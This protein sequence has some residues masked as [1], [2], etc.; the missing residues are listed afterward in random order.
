MWMRPCKWCGKPFPVGDGPRRNVLTC[1]AE[2]RDQRNADLKREY[3][4]LYY[5][6][7]RGYWLR[8]M[9]ERAKPAARRGVPA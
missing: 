5:A 4:R 7:K 9:A 6:N 3:C 1:S 2:C 8:Y